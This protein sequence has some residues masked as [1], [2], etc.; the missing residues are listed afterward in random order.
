[1]DGV[2]IDLYLTQDIL[3]KQ[4]GYIKVSSGR[5]GSTFSLFFKAQGGTGLSPLMPL[6]NSPCL[7]I[8]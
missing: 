7:L 8:H 4:N 6:K 3:N 1:M 2:G 5:D